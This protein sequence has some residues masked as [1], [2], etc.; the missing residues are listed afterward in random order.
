[1]N[2]IRERLRRI[3]L[4]RNRIERQ[5]NIRERTRNLSSTTTSVLPYIRRSGKVRQPPSRAKKPSIPRPKKITK[6]KKK[7]EKKVIKQTKFPN[8]IIN[9]YNLSDELIIDIENKLDV[10]DYRSDILKHNNDGIL[11]AKKVCQDKINQGYINKIFKNDNNNYQGNFIYYDNILLGFTNY[12][13]KPKKEM[14]YINLLCVNKKIYLKGLPLGK[15]LL[16]LVKLNIKKYKQKNPKT[17]IRRLRLDAIPEA[18]DFYIKYG[19]YKT[20]KDFGLIE[21]DYLL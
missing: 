21:M 12:Y 8:E 11:L 4:E 1:M 2:D 6:F 17:K 19:F 14:Y 3:N 9:K 13:R 15:L 16:D 10:V 5:R 7:D 20:G 18:V